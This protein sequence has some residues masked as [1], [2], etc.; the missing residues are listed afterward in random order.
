V[1]TGENVRHT[2]K[3]GN[4][5]AGEYKS[6]NFIYDLTHQSF[7]DL[8]L[9]CCSALLFPPLDHG[10]PVFLEGGPL[11]HR[12]SRYVA[13]GNTMI[14]TGDL[15]AT[16]FINTIFQFQLEPVENNYS[17]GPFIKYQPSKLPPGVKALGDV[18][19]QYGA[20]VTTIH[21]FSLPVGTTVFFA[22]PEG[23]PFF[24]IK[25]CEVMNPKQ[26]EPP[27]K[28]SPTSCP[29]WKKKGVECGCGNIIYVGYSW[30]DDDNEKWNAALRSTLDL[31]IGKD[32]N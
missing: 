31:V 1:V 25:Y 22:S 29:K 19:Q 15:T 17:P 24:S 5:V 7:R 28:V 21:K 20:D 12:I 32:E 18:L 4:I 8:T 2:V 30:V 13:N 23:S 9:T 11:A 14:F 3:L 10:F 6:P 26:G 16:L 27:I